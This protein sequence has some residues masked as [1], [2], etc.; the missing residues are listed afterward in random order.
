MMNGYLE[1]LQKAWD[2]SMQLL[3]EKTVL[4]EERARLLKEKSAWLKERTS[5]AKERD[6]LLAENEQLRSCLV[7][8]T[9]S[10]ERP[11]S[12]KSNVLKEQAFDHAK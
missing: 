7:E 6:G 1:K 2:T 8:V 4:L 9:H 3:T 5:L 12:S 10:R 11:V